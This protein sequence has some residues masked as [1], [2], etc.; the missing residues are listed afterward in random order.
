[1]FINFGDNNRLDGMGFAAFANVSEGM[2]VVDKLNQEYD[3]KPEQGAIQA[4]GGAYLSQNFPRLDKIISAVII[5]PPPAAAPAKPAA[6][7]PPAAKPTVAPAK[8]KPVAP[9]K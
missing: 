3:E 7:K 5:D 2:D 4:K 6:A 9:A 8:P 1:M